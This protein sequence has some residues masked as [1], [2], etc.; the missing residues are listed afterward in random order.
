MGVLP[1]AQLEEWRFGV[2]G[3]EKT[4]NP[5]TEVKVFAALAVAATGG[6]WGSGSHGAP[7]GGSSVGGRARALQTLVGTQQGLAVR[8]VMVHILECV[9]TEGDQ[10]AAG[11]TPQQAEAPARQPGQG[12]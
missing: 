10:A 12:A 3:R 11:H 5:H 9:H 8:A 6:L 2:P 7:P 1:R 4:L